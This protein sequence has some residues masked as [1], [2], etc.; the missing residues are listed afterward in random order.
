M[1]ELAVVGPFGEG[2]LADQP[3]FDPVHS[4]AGRQPALAKRRLAAF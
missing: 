3:G 1:P 2:D 4:P